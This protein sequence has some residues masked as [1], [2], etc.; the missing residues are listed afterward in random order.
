MTFKYLEIWNKLKFGGGVR[1]F[2]ENERK[3]ERWSERERGE[4]E[5][6]R[7]TE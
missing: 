2:R 1:V 3:R 5:L 4:M 7:E 6:K